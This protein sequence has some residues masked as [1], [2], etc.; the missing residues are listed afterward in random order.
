MVDTSKMRL[1]L[2][3]PADVPKHMVEKYMHA[4]E[5][6]ASYCLGGMGYDSWMR[7]LSANK[8]DLL[9]VLANDSE[10]IGTVERHKQITLSQQYQIY[11][12]NITEKIRRCLNGS[13]GD[14]R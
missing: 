5:P 6:D 14:S 1:T 8:H 4:V 7:M 10:V 13:G 2:Q 3:R 9:I 12:R 11:S